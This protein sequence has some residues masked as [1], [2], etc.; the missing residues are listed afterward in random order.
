M[1]KSREQMQD[2]TLA[3]FQRA[4]RSA[5]T[6]SDYKEIPLSKQLADADKWDRMSPSDRL[7]SITFSEWWGKLLTESERLRKFSRGKF[8]DWLVMKRKDILENYHKSGT[9]FPEVIKWMDDQ[10]STY[11]NL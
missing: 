3:G 7:K 8:T 4:V 10:Q 1:A 6:E 2:A 5:G 9:M 11:R